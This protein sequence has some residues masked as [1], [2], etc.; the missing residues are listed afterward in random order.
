MILRSHAKINLILKVFDKSKDLH[1][2]VS[3]MDKI[4]LHDKLIVNTNKSGNL[5]VKFLNAKIDKMNNTVMKALIL[6]KEETKFKQ[7]IIVE[8]IKNIPL[9]SG[10]G[11]GSSNAA[12]VLKY[13]N[14]KLKLNLSTKKLNTIAFKV[15]S[16]VPSFLVDG[17]VLISGHGENVL[18]VEL[19]STSSFLVVKPKFGV[20]AKLAYQ[21]YDKLKKSSN[22]MTS[23]QVIALIQNENIYN[24]MTNDLQLPVLNNV[25]SLN[26]LHKHLNNY[27]FDKVIMTGSG[28]AFI[29]FSSNK[30]LLVKARKELSNKYDFVA[31]SK[32]LKTR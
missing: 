4:E 26:K 7:G 8:V 21:F 10:L 25:A 22:K 30:N 18:K 2:I 14:E 15:G 13:L 16:D 20:S 12:V 6:L 17:P 32:R 3:V 27:N 28:S 31:I 9:A 23:K 24:S 11:G 19:P 1:P 29:A 5:A